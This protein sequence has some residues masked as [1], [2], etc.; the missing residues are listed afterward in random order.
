MHF[1]YILHEYVH[2][3][4][5]YR[6]MC[7]YPGKDGYSNWQD[8]KILYN[9]TILSSLSTVRNYKLKTHKFIAYI[10]TFTPLLLAKKNYNKIKHLCIKIIRTQ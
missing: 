8:R 7:H 10:K 2:Y 1:L 3:I 6:Y 9:S 5:S 4:I